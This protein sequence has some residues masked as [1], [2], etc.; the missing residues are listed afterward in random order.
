MTARA[1]SKPSTQIKY[2]PLN[3]GLD[4][5][6][7]PQSVDPGFALAMS[8]FECWYNGGYRRVDGYERFSGKSKP[9]AATMYGI[10][11][12]S[13]SGI[14]LSSY[15]GTSTRT[16]LGGTGVSSGAT[17]QFVQGVSVGGTNYLAFTPITGT[18]TAGEYLYIGTTTSTGTTLAVPS[19]NYAPAGT[20]SSGYTYSSEFLAGCQ[21][22]YRQQVN[23]VPGTGNVLGAW[24]NG[25]NIYAVRGTGTTGTPAKLYL[26]SAAG[27]TTSGITYT[28][29]IYLSTS[30]TQGFPSAGS[31]VTAGGG[32][33]TMYQGIL[34]GA[35]NGPGYIALTNIIGT[36]T[37]NIALMSGGTGF[38]TTASVGT[39]ADTPFALPSTGFYRWRNY[40][41]L[42]NSSAYYTY[43]V[44]GQGPA[45]QIDQNNVVMPILLPLNPQTGQ[46]AANTP[47]LV[48]VYQNYLALAFPGGNFQ[49]SVVG[50][51]Y[52]YN[53]FLGAAQFGVGAEITGMHSIV[54]P[55]LAIMTNRN[56]QVL[57]GNAATGNSP[58]AMALVAEHAGATKYGSIS[59][60]TVYALNSLGIT[61]LSRTQSYGNFAGATVS[62]LIQPMLQALT[63]TGAGQFADMTL[64]RRSN[65]ARIYFT[66]GDTISM[67]VPGLGQQNKAWSAIETGVT[68]QF[69]H[70]VYPAPVYNTSNSED[71]YGNE[72]SYF[73]SSN[74]D[75]YVY[76][77]RSG[78]S[79]DG[80]AIA[81]YVKL[82]FNNVGSP[83]MRKFFRRADLEINSTVPLQLQVA[84]DLSYSTQ[85]NAAEVIAINALGGG[86]Y[87]DSSAYFN[88]T[89]F[90]SSTASTARVSLDGTAQNISLLIYHQSITDPPFI[91]Q[92][93]SL[94]Y[95]P[96]RYQR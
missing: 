81:S 59:L 33:G 76:Q 41:F 53:G 82:V 86:G 1:A 17:A 49:L 13:M 42:A 29:T 7:P 27:W 73:G 75:G 51:P 61:S 18:F 65:Q 87:Y 56:S 57:T 88:Q 83:V 50:V 24:Q 31:I 54:G 91:L 32:T 8:N 16:G 2:W 55:A 92:G 67:Y 9:S 44:N 66:T 96:R 69:G 94:H 63:G 6:T 84:T 47:F 28:D 72:T 78:T 89:Y 25:T 74:G 5:V 93:I 30:G 20:G 38:G 48:E 43:G 90:D 21:N 46:P 23:P 95:D 19:L 52:Q 45:F 71:Q 36:F 10:T 58:F 80:A 11:V 34:H 12:S 15:M 79:W 62:Q 37:S 22:Y 77:A 60:D 14:S 35:V 68:T 26:S 39:R 40:N 70:H 3:G 4:L 85:E 64:V